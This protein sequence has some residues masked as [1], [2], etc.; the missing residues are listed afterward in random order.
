[1]I[2]RRD[3]RWGQSMEKHIFPEN[4]IE[5]HYRDTI[6]GKLEIKNKEPRF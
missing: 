6:Y 2:P 3:C 1:M 4:L 5:S